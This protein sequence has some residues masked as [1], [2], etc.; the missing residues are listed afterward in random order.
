MSNCYVN[1]RLETREC[2]DK[3]FMGTTH[4]LSAVAAFLAVIYFFPDL[5]SKSLGT[6]DPWVLILSI[7]VAAG[8]SLVPDLD[9]TASTSKSSLGMLGTA[10][11]YIF[12]GSSRFI[13][14]VV[15]TKRDDPTPN[16]HRGAWHTI[17]SALL[18]GYLTYLGTSMSKSITVPL[19]G[20]ITWGTMFALLI[21]FLMVHMALA[22]LAKK[23][24]KK[25]KKT[26]V[27]GEALTFIVSFSST[28]IIFVN[29]PEGLNF[30]WLGVSVAFGCFIHILGDTFTT[31]GT[32]ILFPFSAFIKGKFWWTTRFTTLKVGEATEKLIFGF[33]FVASI[34]FAVLILISQY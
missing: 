14:T 26:A 10:L 33:F 16:P 1:E 27:I 19:L 13:Q 29:L 23:Q 3:A 8:A 21:T 12:R 34:V 20:T 6:N 32:P 15:R 2:S 24:M 4:A 7:V 22:G 31:A 30:W 11:S 25:I 17:P 28:L 18:L 9:N 5:V